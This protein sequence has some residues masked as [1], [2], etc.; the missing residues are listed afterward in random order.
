MRRVSVL[1]GPYRRPG[2]LSRWLRWVAFLLGV[3]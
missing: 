2:I 1:E 3:N